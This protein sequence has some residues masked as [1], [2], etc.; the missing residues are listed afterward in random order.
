MPR[1]SERGEIRAAFT[2]PPFLFVTKTVH[3]VSGQ[4][5]VE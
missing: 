2:D 1:R 3:W 4:R 5:A